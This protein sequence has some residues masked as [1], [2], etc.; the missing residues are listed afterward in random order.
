MFQR[1]QT[2]LHRL[3]HTLSM[4]QSLM[5]TLHF[6]K[7]LGVR[8]RRY[9]GLR[10][11]CSMSRGTVSSMLRDCFNDGVVMPEPIFGEVAGVL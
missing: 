10:Q 1:L 9:T 3:E 5:E 4:S 6:V 11:R 7:Q 2:G 8:F